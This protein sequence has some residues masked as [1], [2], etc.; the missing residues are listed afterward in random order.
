MIKVQGVFRVLT[1]LGVLLAL[2]LA[3]VQAST[4]GKIAGVVTDANTGDAL[5]NA[6][7]IVV[8]SAMGTT[9][10]EKGRFFILNVPTGTYTLRA[11]Y[12]GYAPIQI[13]DLI[14][15]TGLTS[16][17][18]IG[19]ASAKIQVD[20]M[21]IKAERPIIDKNATNAVRIINADDLEALPLRSS[22]EVVALQ[23]GVIL[24]DGDLHVRGS[25]VDEIAYYIEGTSTRNPITGGSAAE[26]VDEAIEEIQVQ[27]G[28][29]NA[30]YG[31]ATAGVVIHQLRTGGTAWEFE[32]V[33]E[34]DGGVST[35]ESLGA[36]GYGEKITVFTAGGP[37]GGKVRL[38]TAL[39]KGE[40]G[41]PP[42]YWD[43]FE[44][45]NLVD[46]G[47]RGGGVHW[48]DADEDGEK[49][50][51]KVDALIVNPGTI[52][53][54]REQITRANT[55]M[56]LDLNPI[57]LKLTHIL[58][59]GNADSPGT[60]IRN[61][62]NTHRLAESDYQQNML[63]LKATHVLSAN[64]IYDVTLSYLKNDYESYDP[65]F[66]DDFMLYNDS[67][68]VSRMGEAEKLDFAS[69]SRAGS[70]PRDY[71]FNGFPFT[72][73]GATMTGYGKQSDGYKGVSGSVTNQGKVHQLKAGFDFQSWQT[74]RYSIAGLG[75]IRNQINLSHPELEAV[76]DRY[77]SGEIKGD[78]LLSEL[79]SAAEAAGKYEDLQR[80]IRQNSRG[81][82]FGFDEFGREQE[83]G[84]SLGGDLEAPRSPQFASAYLQDKIEYN[85]LIVN[86]GLRLDYFDIDSWDIVKDEEGR[87]VLNRDEKNYTL[88]ISDDA[89]KTYMTRS[90]S[91]TKISPRLG[92]SFP[93]SD[94]TVMHVQYGKFAQMPA[95]RSS[96]TGGARLALET[97]GQ[98]FIS[99]P[100]AFNLE[101]MMTTQYE[102][103]LERQFT[104]LASFDITGFYR[105]VRGQMQLRN[106]DLSPSSIGASGG[107]NYLQN[108][109]F[110]T[111]K[112][113]EFV[114]KIRRS[115]GFR[116][117][118][119]YTLQ[120]ARGTGSSTLSAVAGVEVRTNLPTLEQ[121][122]DFNQKHT[123][124]VL[125]DYK[126]PVSG[127]IFSGVYASV[128]TSFSSGH[129]YTLVGGS[130]GQRG[131]EDGAVMDDFDPRSRKPLESVNAS[132]TPWTYETNLKI[133]KKMS[134]RGT[135]VTLYLRAMNLFNRKNVINVYRRTGNASDD[136]FLN[137]PE[138]SQQIVAARGE[139]YVDMFEK[140]NL[141]NRQHYST[142]QGGDL[143]DEPRQVRIGLSLDF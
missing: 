100:T 14:V 47:D 120:D 72:R 6:N 123:G 75:S 18:D 115:K 28:G 78:K 122:L 30:E 132:T 38:F 59:S 89:G 76:Y 4:G 65:Y 56:L 130:L 99:A 44:L 24:Q 87:A 9:A 131:P 90:K 49:E 110:A 3:P 119:N 140:I 91:H 142:N 41:S 5:P 116:T 126:V 86:A 1:A 102:I 13:Q 16:S 25:R 27:A 74:R 129:N 80:L 133:G 83:G 92:F 53:H 37:L 32:L 50:P 67:T 95:L 77:Y 64:T 12:I 48:Q 107:Y 106:Q 23:P 8:D 135:N 125:L 85:D 22:E 57:T 121:P 21:I 45:N 104:D 112:G 11:T 103:G 137:S 43:G 93:V 42:M 54:A 98:N 29:F 36:Y 35:S 96:L 51:D 113:I 136:G 71:D 58:A 79:I 124:S 108:G 39:S 15:S 82:F 143:F 61:I 2:S 20:E 114:L 118:I 68:A 55:T 109:D 128:L 62:L 63:S 7:I 138:L 97:G 69:F 46:T 101:P 141:Q 10:D 31:G 19:M 105:D 111:T 134:L 70:A 84:K 81:D 139:E 127:G 33:S 34:N 17:V 60:P 94:R 117:E 40:A 52:A 73:P 88:L 26:L 66:E